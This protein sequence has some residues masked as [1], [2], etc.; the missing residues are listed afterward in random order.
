MSKLNNLSGGYRGGSNKSTPQKNPKENKSL[1]KN[2][3]IEDF[4]K[5][6][7]SY[8]YNNDVS[9]EDLLNYKSCIEAFNEGKTPDNLPSTPFFT[10]LVNFTKN[11][12]E[13]HSVSNSHLKQQIDGIDNI[14]KT[15]YPKIIEQKPSPKLNGKINSLSSGYKK[16]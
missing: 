8:Y 13:S 3:D 16:K 6:L 11:M 5:T 12:L 1:D 15:T 10:N 14:L 9:K 4:I 7:T 2:K